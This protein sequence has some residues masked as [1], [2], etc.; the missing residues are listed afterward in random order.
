MVPS[1]FYVQMEEEDLY[2]LVV[3]NIFLKTLRDLLRVVLHR[4]ILVADCQWCE[5]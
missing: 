4:S 5:T 1:Q 2:M 3:Q